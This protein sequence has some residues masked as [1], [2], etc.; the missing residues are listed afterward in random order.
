M[1]SLLLDWAEGRWLP[2]CRHQNHPCVRHPW[3]LMA[4]LPPAVALSCQSL[5]PLPAHHHLGCCCCCHGAS[6]PSQQLCSTRRPFGASRALLQ[7]GWCCCAHAAQCGWC[8][9][10][11]IDCHTGIGPRQIRCQQLPLLSP[12][13]IGLL[14]YAV[15]WPAG[16]ADCLPFACSRL[17]CGPPRTVVGGMQI[18]APPGVNVCLPIGIDLR[19][20]SP[21]LSVLE[22]LLLAQQLLLQ[23]VCPGVA[24]RHKWPIPCPS[25]PQ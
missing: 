8:H 1:L 6:R 18:R 14:L 7:T 4:L 9:S 12:I 20:T 22:T 5:L 16:A 24:C 23:E 25:V 11:S 10:S 17:W 2:C 19:D 13:L 3:L 15:G 21:L